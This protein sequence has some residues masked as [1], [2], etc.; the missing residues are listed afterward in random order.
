MKLA[1]ILASLSLTAGLFGAAA[2]AQDVT[3]RMATNAPEKTIW[4]EQLD[5]FAAHVAE[6]SEGR[7]K[8]DIFYNGQLGSENAVLA[9]VARGRI[10]MTV[11]SVSSIADQLP[12]AYLVSMLF[13]YD[14]VA[15]RS[16]ILAKVSEDY[17][18]LIAPA[19]VR[20]LDWY[21]TGSGQLSGS[22]AFTTPDMMAHK[23]IGV[24]ANKISNAYWERLKAEPVMTP[25]T[26]AASS[27]STGLIDAYPT[28]PVFYVFGGINK[29][30]PVL[31]RLDYVMSPAAMLI[32]ERSWKTLSEE[33]RA[34]LTRAIAAETAADRSRTFFDFEEQVM[35]MHVEA[36]GELV[37]PTADELA[38]WRAGIDDYYTEIVNGLSDEGKAFFQTM[39]AA[40]A[41]CQP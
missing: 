11:N 39:E 2:Q 9:Q 15:Q 34:A 36:G 19:G 10:D 32:S 35:K 23:R 12:E 21:E 14:S 29:I 20:F 16:C 27:L 38:Q 28:I 5:R 1:N 31:T 40:K 17:R 25:A 4:Q 6:E 37:T 24:S 26:E 22:K 18:A 41:D 33:D 7:I 13:Y 30:A 3:L 8:V